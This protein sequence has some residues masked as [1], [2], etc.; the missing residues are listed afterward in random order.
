MAVAGRTST[1]SLESFAPLEHVSPSLLLP[2][3][4]NPLMPPR[5]HPLSPHTTPP[6]SPDTPSSTHKSLS[7]PSPSES[8]ST[9]ST[10]FENLDI[11]DEHDRR[12]PNSLRSQKPPQEALL[13]ELHP[14]HGFSEPD[15]EMLEHAHQEGDRIQGRRSK[16]ASESLAF[17]E[18]P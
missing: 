2:A 3:R 18:C 1:G 6:L 4:H 13:D 15:A 8:S 7:S 11:K 14:G 12:S 16:P 17:S 10:P 9:L 5:Q